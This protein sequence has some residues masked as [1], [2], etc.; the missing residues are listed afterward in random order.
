MTKRMKCH[1]CCNGL[2]F[3]LVQCSSFSPYMNNHISL[4]T[5][6]VF[7]QYYHAVLLIWTICFLV[8]LTLFKDYKQ[9]RCP[10]RCSPIWHIQKLTGSDLYIIIYI[11]PSI[12]R[13]SGQINMNEFFR[14]SEIWIDMSC[15]WRLWYVEWDICNL[16]INCYLDEYSVLYYTRCITRTVV[17]PFPATNFQHLSTY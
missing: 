4:W 10:T 17:K 12:V 1:D 8:F 3:G 14:K 16:C 15:L 2:L 5:A 11:N 9:D 6:L 7:E 13:T